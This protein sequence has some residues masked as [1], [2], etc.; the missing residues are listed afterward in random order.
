MHGDSGTDS[1]VFCEQ[2]KI[3]TKN[4]DLQTCKLLAEVSDKFNYSRKCADDIAIA[5]QETWL[6]LNKN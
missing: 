6:R 1:Y 4:T 2:C 5:V 3:K